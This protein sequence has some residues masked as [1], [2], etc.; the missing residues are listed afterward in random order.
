MYIVTFSLT[1]LNTMSWFF[2]KLFFRVRVKT[3]LKNLKV[4]SCYQIWAGKLHLF[5]FWKLFLF[6]ISRYIT[7]FF[8]CAAVIEMFSSFLIWNS[9]EVWTIYSM[10]R[11]AILCPSEGMWHFLHF[12]R[13]NRKA[14]V[15]SI[16][17]LIPFT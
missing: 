2:C 16:L 10:S 14:K 5:F 13:E 8:L 15:T 9:C 6:L 12:L 1:L 4:R 17:D 3:F 11:T 7:L